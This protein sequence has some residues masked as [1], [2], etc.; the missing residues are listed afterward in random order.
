MSDIC[1]RLYGGSIRDC[2]CRLAGPEGGWLECPAEARGVLV[3][4]SVADA[5]VARNAVFRS[6]V[7]ALNA[8]VSIGLPAPEAARLDEAIKRIP[9]AIDEAREADSLSA[10]NGKIPPPGGKAMGFT[11]NICSNCQGVRMVRNGVCETC[12]DCF[13]TGECG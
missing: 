2:R 10:A 7:H 1:N 8:G 9:A 13:H 11:G 3:P 5:M 12:L 4:Q 6:E